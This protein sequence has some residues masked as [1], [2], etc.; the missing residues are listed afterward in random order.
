MCRSWRAAQALDNFLTHHWLGSVPA[1]ARGK[2]YKLETLH[3]RDAMHLSVYKDEWRKETDRQRNRKGTPEI[4][5]ATSKVEVKVNLY[6]KP[7]KDV[8]RTHLQTRRWIKVCGQRQAS[9]ILTRRNKSGSHCTGSWLGLAV[10]QVGG[11]NSPLPPGFEPK[12]TRS[13]SVT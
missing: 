5:E 10:S 11:G 2:W 7:R 6:R 4:V 13:R 3:S 9:V 12:T 8:W 1:T